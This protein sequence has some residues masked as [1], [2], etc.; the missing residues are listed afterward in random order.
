MCDQ[1]ATRKLVCTRTTMVE[2][3]AQNHTSVYPGTAL[4][5]WRPDPVPCAA[6]DGVERA[7]DDCVH[8][9]AIWRRLVVSLII[10]TVALVLMLDGIF[11]R[12][13]LRP[14]G[15]KAN[16]AAIWEM[17][18]VLVATVTITDVEVHPK[19]APKTYGRLRALAAEGDDAADF[20]PCRRQCTDVRCTG[21]VRHNDSHCISVAQ[22]KSGSRSPAGS[23]KSH[24]L[25]PKAGTGNA[26]KLHRS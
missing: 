24:A 10:G 25:D 23:G 14:G 22:L 26:G 18:A 1:S 11:R 16:R 2:L 6:P 20:D 9:D 7:E 3:L 17:F 4:D 21:G 19:D 15:L 13:Q 5:V 12:P 8:P